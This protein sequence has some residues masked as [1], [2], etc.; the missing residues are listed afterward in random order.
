MGRIRPSH[1]FV[2]AT[3]L[4]ASISASLIASAGTANVQV[5][6]PS[7][8]L[9]SPYTFTI[10]AQSLSFSNALRIPHIADGA[11]WTTTFAVE[12]LDL[13]PVSY[14]FNF[15]GDGGSAFPSSW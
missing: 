14:A 2:S 3:Q 1:H 4:T 10:L 5:T 13:Q 9:T 6:N 15:W 7:G 8:Y 11:G 12:N